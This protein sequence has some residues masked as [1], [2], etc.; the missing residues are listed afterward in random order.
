MQDASKSPEDFA[1]I[2][3]NAEG[4]EK[5]I[6]FDNPE[7]QESKCNFIRIGEFCRRHTKE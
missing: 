5:Q 7:V 4:V 2:L 6:F 1:M 3:K